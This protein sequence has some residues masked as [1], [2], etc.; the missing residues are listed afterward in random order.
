MTLQQEIEAAAGKAPDKDKPMHFVPAQKLDHK[1]IKQVLR[2][3]YRVGSSGKVSIVEANK[4]ELTRSLGVN[5]RDL[6]ILDANS[7]GGSSYPSCILCR[8][9]A[10]VIN[11]EYIQVCAQLVQSPLAI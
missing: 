3:W 9:R 11:L 6:R 10:L 5:S 2:R 4:Y 7:G 8:D 1:Q